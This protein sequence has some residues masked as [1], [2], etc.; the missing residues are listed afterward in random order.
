MGLCGHMYRY[1]LLSSYVHKK[2]RYPLTAS[3]SHGTMVT[4][5]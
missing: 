5:G 1:V 3:V 4:L 2:P